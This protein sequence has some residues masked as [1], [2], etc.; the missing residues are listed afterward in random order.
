MLGRITLASAVL[1]GVLA[2]QNKATEKTPEFSDFPINTLFHGVPA[3]PKVSTPG[4]RRFRTMIRQGAKK[5]ANFAG[6]YAV[7][8]WGCGTHRVTH[9]KGFDFPRP[10]RRK[11]Q[12]RPIL[13]QR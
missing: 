10:R 13:P 9:S 2:G 6:H 12:D 8:E 7:A 11:R 5:G 1:L 3:A 4:Q